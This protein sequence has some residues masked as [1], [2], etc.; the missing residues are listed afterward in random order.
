M[1][2]ITC[3]APIKGVDDK[4]A[5]AFKALNIPMN[6]HIVATLRG[7]YDENTSY[8]KGR[9]LVTARNLTNSEALEA[10]K[11]LY[12]Y[13]QEL[14]KANAEAIN[15]AG[16]T[17]ATNYNN[18]HSVFT[19]QEIQ[20][21]VNNIVQ[22][23]MNILDFYEKRGYSRDDIINGFDG[24]YGEDFIYQQV[25][26]HLATLLSQEAGFVKYGATHK[27]GS[28]LSEEEKT[29]LINKV[30]IRKATLDNWATL[31]VFARKKLSALE[32]LKQGKYTMSNDISEE[33]NDLESIFDPSESIR[34]GF[35]SSNGL[36]SAFG[37]VG[38]S[39]RRELARTP[40]YRYDEQTGNVVEV[41]DDLGCTIN[42]DP[43]SAHQAIINITRTCTTAQ[44]MV[45]ALR[46]AGIMWKGLV[47]KLS[48]DPQFR[49]KFYVDMSKASE[50][51]CMST[52]D[53]SN[54]GTKWYF[55]KWLSRT[56]STNQ[57]K[58]YISR[59]RNYATSNTVFNSN[60]EIIPNV[61]K[62]YKDLV[63]KLFKV[64]NTGETIFGQSVF[65]NTGEF[66]NYSLINKRVAIKQCFD[67]F[68]IS[69]SIDVID[70]IL[71]N[72]SDSKKLI[73]NLI[74][75]K[76]L[77]A[78]PNYKASLQESKEGNKTGDGERALTNIFSLLEEHSKAT[79]LPIENAC[80]WKNDKGQRITLYT[81]VTPSYMS[82][83][84][85]KVKNF[86]LDNDK[87]GLKQFLLNEYGSNRFY[88]D[89]S[90]D[91][92]NNSILQSLYTSCDSKKDLQDT[93]AGNFIYM[94]FLGNDDIV[95]ENMSSKQHLADMWSQYFQD[96]A[97]KNN[98]LIPVFVL[99]DSGISKYVVTERK[100][101]STIIKGLSNIY[102]Q[103][104]TRQ[105][106]VRELNEWCDA[107]RYSRV[108]N[109]ENTE[110][111]FTALPFLNK[112]FYGGKYYKMLQKISDK[113]DISSI[114]KIFKEY[115]ADRYIEFSKMLNKLG[116]LEKDTKG[117]FIYLKDATTKNISD[118]IKRFYN[119]LMYSTIEYTQLMTV[120]PAFYKSN[121]GGTNVIDDLQKRFKEVHAPGSVVDITAE[122][123]Q[124]NKICPDN[125][126]TYLYFNDVK[127]SLDKSNKEFMDLIRKTYKDDPDIISA[128]YKTSLTDGQGYRTLTSYRKVMIMAGQWDLN[129][130]Q[131]EAYNYIM[132]LRADHPDGNYSKS[133]LKELGRI[134][135]IFQPIKPFLFTHEKLGIY[136]DNSTVDIPV[137]HKYAEVVIIPELLPKG[138]MLKDVA[139]YMDTHNIDVFCS[140]T[141]VKVGAF[142]AANIQE[143]TDRESLYKS[144][145]AGYVHTLKQSDYRIQ[146]NVPNHVYE[147]R[148]FG[149]QARKLFYTAINKTKIYDYLGKGTRVK[150]AKHLAPVE[151]T[152]NNLIAFYNALNVAKTLINLI[153]FKNLVKDKPKLSDILIRNVISASKECLDNINALAIVEK[154][155]NMALFEAG[156]EHDTAAL[157]LSLFKNIVNKQKIMGGSAV[158]ASSLGIKGYTE[159]GGLKEIVK[160][161]NVE[162]AEIEV[163]FDFSYTDKNGKII[164]LDYDDY[165]NDDG[166]F[167]IDEITNKPKIETD[168]PGITDLICYRIPSERCYS[169]INAKIVRCSRK[170]FGGVIRVP[171]AGTT[172]S[173]FDFDIDKLYFIRK[174]F[175]VKNREKI[176]DKTT[177]R[178]LSSLLGKSNVSG[179]YI[180]EFESYDPSKSPLENSETAINNMLFTLI[181]KRLSDKETLEA[182]TTPGSF[183]HAS[184]GARYIRELE[185]GDYDKVLSNGTLNKEYINKHIKEDPEFKPNYDYTN[186]ITLMYLN[187]QNQVAAKV[188]GIFAN[189]NINT[190]YR[191]LLKEFKLTTPIEFA[192]KSLYDL[193]NTPTNVEQT[194]AEFLAASVD[195][196]KDPVLNFLGI[197][198]LTA[199]SAGLLGSLG[200][201]ME[202]IGVLLR[203][204]IVKQICEYAFNNNTTIDIATKEVLSSNYD[205]KDSLTKIN[206]DQTML[207]FDAL[208]TNIVM[209]SQYDRLEQPYSKSFI[210]G[211]LQVAALF[212]NV[213]QTASQLSNFIQA[214]KFTAA[215]S[216]GSTFGDMIAQQYKVENFNKALMVPDSKLKIVLND[217]NNNSIIPIKENYKLNDAEDYLKDMA[218]NP[219]AIEQCMYDANKQCL[220][221]LEDEF[222]YQ[223]DMF[224]TPRNILRASTKN[225]F[226][227]AETINAMHRDA[228]V[229]A[230]SNSVHSKFN[231]DLIINKN[232]QTQREYYILEF[233]QILENLL[234][235]DPDLKSMAVFRNINFTEGNI[236]INGVKHTDSLSFNIAGFGSNKA[237][238][239]AKDEIM[240]SW[241]DLAISNNPKYKQL[242]VD[243]FI[244][245]FYKSGFNYNY[246]SFIDL[247]PVAVKNLIKVPTNDNSNPNRTYKEFLEEIKNGTETINNTI[248]FSR[249]FILNHLD[250]YLFT[251][252]IKGKYLTSIINKYAMSGTSYVDSFTIDIDNISKKDKAI[253]N[254]IINNS[255]KSS[256]GTKYHYLPV[257]K[258]G[259]NYYMADNILLTDKNKV[260]YTKVKPL[261]KTN[262]SSS[263]YSNYEGQGEVSINDYSDVEI[264][265]D[266]SSEDAQP[267]SYITEDSSED[268]ILDALTEATLL[269]N[270]VE[271]SPVNKN[272]VKF[273]LKGTNLQEK[274]VSIRQQL[275]EKGLDIL[276]ENGK[277]VKSC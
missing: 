130:P 230:L 238:G 273:T 15:S 82:E 209:G 242:A 55:T 187:Q 133:E 258:I 52:K 3:Y 105:N 158:Q 210:K 101:E 228:I 70:S 104:L 171:A 27:D 148:L 132:Q 53:S 224:F 184:T 22:M 40:S 88:Y 262:I 72:S 206:A 86:V 41:K 112:D 204:P 223:K 241:A 7:L 1:R 192:G 125:K 227:N 198:T 51:Y 173:G 268:E 44:Q 144:L 124:G 135:V 65:K 247:A 42:L 257:I 277:I 162:Y 38:K 93:Y 60:G 77:T 19:A 211:Q 190:V 157:C 169:M 274:L 237:K 188:I 2:D 69:A 201:S 80:S 56:K 203:Q 195:A 256:T 218:D 180:S 131:E 250:N 118:K 193:I 205:Y 71:R 154:S 102:F 90:S 235:K 31:V 123:K 24:K 47:I 269:I 83:L 50:E 4:I 73:Q 23:A 260:T 175:K 215:N 13:R 244:Y 246:L 259:N 267:L 96:S 11:L 113:S 266:N 57:Y 229:Y 272:L 207:S 25:F 26:K 59:Y 152:G 121:K 134:A 155:F 150:L 166:T 168:F 62:E 151:L 167:I 191:K 91:T 199:N 147:S 254:I 58:D 164:Y 251:R 248:E 156:I 263:Y 54:S 17:L 240:Q 176:T 122:D 103:E 189:H 182:R 181:Q 140:T 9:Q 66:Y 153:E 21:R 76:Y 106:Q 29:N 99:G 129:G 137:Q 89:S 265:L 126:A 108:A 34:G 138:N 249:Q 97:G 109:F 48:T 36:K 10:A 32:G 208:S 20:W 160:D 111:I 196:V 110:N 220:E 270:G 165:C 276:N 12:K 243:L 16:T 28:A 163:P 127:A 61:L 120:D 67:Y 87:Q 231:G 39:V 217:N 100:S 18:L 252:E 245:C 94:R 183:R 178:L 128:Y 49:T 145:D 5:E 234:S 222:P 45:E 30:A 170:Q 142:G 92:F 233:P 221:L 63:N 79:A 85:K 64:E 212:S 68:G 159:D 261:G 35:S 116:L 146:T 161:G 136:K 179:S 264:P 214:T 78:S 8:N 225:N 239:T 107:N 255:E 84:H 33:D 172:I 219:F 236:Y 141:C 202:E 143:A 43:V 232:G 37:T 81:S 74:R 271:S 75:L 115:L 275:K 194:M 46:D 95:F 226:L 197:N 185:F 119:N 186:P 149:T 174:E 216:V 200:Y 213:Y 117:N 139:E 114:E 253:K 6:R 98:S 177:N 14:N